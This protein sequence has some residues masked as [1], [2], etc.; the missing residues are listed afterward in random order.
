MLHPRQV[1]EVGETSEETS[2]SRNQ[3][4]RGAGNATDHVAEPTWQE[5]PDGRPGHRA[6]C[7]G[8]GSLGAIQGC[9]DSLSQ[10]IRGK[11]LQSPTP[12]AP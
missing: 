1:E 11:R 12:S 4:A 9:W 3:W 2:L 6:K 8:A 7:P 5:R 10:W